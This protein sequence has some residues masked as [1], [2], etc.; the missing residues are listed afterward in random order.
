MGGVELELHE[1]GSFDAAVSGCVGTERE[2]G[3]WAVEGGRLQLSGSGDYA[4][5]CQR[6]G[7]PV[8]V[9]L[10]DGLPVILSSRGDLYP[11]NSGSWYPGSGAVPPGGSG[12]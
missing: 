11:A 12:R 1:D 8:S 4:R 6:G 10:E 7:W 3:T 2:R 9:M 5:S